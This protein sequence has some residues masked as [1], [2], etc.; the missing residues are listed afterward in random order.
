M[1]TNGIKLADRQFCEQL[2]TAGLDRVSI[3]MLATKPEI[4]ADLAKANDGL[5]RR[6]QTGLKNAVDVFGNAVDINTVLT[7]YNFS[8]MGSLIDLASEYS[9]NLRVI[10]LA[11]SYDST[12]DL[13]VPVAKLKQEL[14]LNGG[15]INC[16]TLDEEFDYNS[17]KLMFRSPAGLEGVKL[18]RP[19]FV[20][21]TP[22]GCL[23]NVEGQEVSLLEEI[24]SRDKQRLDLKLRANSSFLH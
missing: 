9:I 23:K 2:K 14:G 19:D 4:Y 13:Y 12:G 20:W 18:S 21:F 1:D 15:T 8:N 7:T 22:D 17:I 11:D 5:F 24:K 10:E 16:G 6:N 3:T